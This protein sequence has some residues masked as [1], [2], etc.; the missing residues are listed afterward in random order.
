VS[1]VATHVSTTAAHSHSLH[2]RHILAR[3]CRAV[4]SKHVSPCLV[5]VPLQRWP[6][7]PD[8]LDPQREHHPGPTVGPGTGDARGGPVPHIRVSVELQPVS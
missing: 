1:F 3:G 2:G 8:L 7:G 4:P 6:C 5:C